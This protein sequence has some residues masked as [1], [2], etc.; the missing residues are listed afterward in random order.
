MARPK[1]IEVIREGRIVRVLIDGEELPFA[2]PRESVT[3]TVDPAEWPTVSLTLFADQVTV[4][5]KLHS[6]EEETSR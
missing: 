2:L 3:V 4:V 5:N 1:R 6:E